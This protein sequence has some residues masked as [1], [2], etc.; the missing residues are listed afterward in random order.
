MT[1]QHPPHQ[2]K[3]SII[4]SVYGLKLSVQLADH[5]NARCDAYPGISVHARRLPSGFRLDVHSSQPP[6]GGPHAVDRSYIRS[7]GNVTRAINHR[8]TKHLRALRCPLRAARVALFNLVETRAVDGLAWPA[9][10]EDYDKM[11][12]EDV[13]FWVGFVSKLPKKSVDTVISQT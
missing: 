13:E 8:V 1:T 2:A 12:S 11:T 10:E 4:G 7:T 6:W 9:R 5:E 3:G